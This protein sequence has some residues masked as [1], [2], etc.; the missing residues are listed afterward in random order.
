[1]LKI[2]R[3]NTTEFACSLKTNDSATDAAKEFT[4]DKRK[5]SNANDV[6]LAVLDVYY[7]GLSFQTG[8]QKWKNTL[9][10]NEVLGWLSDRIY[11]Y[12]NFEPNTDN[13][14][15]NFD[16]FHKSLCDGY[17]AK[18]NAC[19][20]ETGYPNI[21]YGNAQKI[22]NMVFKYLACYSDYDKYADLFSYCHIPLDRRILCA[23]ND[24]FLLHTNPR[25]ESSI[26]LN[27]KG[28]L[29]YDV[30]YVDA[31]T[32]TPWSGLNYSQYIDIVNIYRSA[33]TGHINN[34]CWLSVDFHYWSQVPLPISGKPKK[35]KYQVS[36][37]PITKSARHISQFYM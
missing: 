10:V 7:S 25:L 6:N 35:Y 2:D 17:Q 8:G 12:F 32:K 15:G 33:M 5:I 16:E 14:Q 36:T 13:T 1:M 4:L 28:D 19:R 3:S 31:H 23:I 24:V 34:H 20:H 18:L 26:H 11:S 30:H 9:E 21:T 27:K 37:I 22:I 29:Q